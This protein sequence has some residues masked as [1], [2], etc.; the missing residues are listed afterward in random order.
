MAVD[1]DHSASVGTDFWEA[2]EKFL[3]GMGLGHG[4]LFV[5]MG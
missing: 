5:E 1:L 3:Y 4:F 2:S